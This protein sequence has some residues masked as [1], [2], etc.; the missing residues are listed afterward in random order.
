[1]RR[2]HNSPAR[3]P[4]GLGQL[5]GGV[6]ED[7]ADAPL[8][9]LIELVGARV[10]D[11]AGEGFG[12]SHF[13]GGMKRE[14]LLDRQRVKAQPR[15]DILDRFALALDFLFRRFPGLPQPPGLFEEA[16]LDLGVRD[17]DPVPLE[18][19]GDQL[20]FHERVQDVV[21]EDLARLGPL[22]LVVN[23]AGAGDLRRLGVN[24]AVGL[25]ED[26]LLADG[27]AIDGHEHGVRVNWRGA[28]AQQQQSAEQEDRR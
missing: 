26:L 9:R 14:Q 16:G 11:P 19:A 23:Q 24:A 7:A 3:F 10:I 2:C 6:D 27:R 28:T 12:Q 1:L 5:G 22:G 8:R 13:V 15:F 4:I 17:F 25:L 21:A 20:P 18:L